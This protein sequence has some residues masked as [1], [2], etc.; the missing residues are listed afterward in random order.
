[1]LAFE[2]D[3]EREREKKSVD[4]SFNWFIFELR[5]TKST[6]Y[7]F[8]SSSFYCQLYLFFLSS[9]QYFLKVSIIQIDSM[10]FFLAHKHYKKINK[11]AIKFETLRRLVI[12]LI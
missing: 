2:E 10:F 12:V 4:Q 11:K 6:N 5:K 8:V 1:M 3:R 9:Y 7:L